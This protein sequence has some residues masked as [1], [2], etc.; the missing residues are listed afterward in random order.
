MTTKTKKAPKAKAPSRSTKAMKPVSEQTKP[1]TDETPVSAM[2][3]VHRLKEQFHV[4][5]EALE[6]E[7]AE[8]Q[9]ALAQKAVRKAEINRKISETLKKKAAAAKKG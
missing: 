3:H 6:A 5:M 2:Q 1:E 8:R 7:D 9:K 4:T